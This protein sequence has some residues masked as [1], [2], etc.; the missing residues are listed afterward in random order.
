MKTLNFLIA[1]LIC[2]MN[3][4]ASIIKINRDDTYI[5][6]D[7][8]DVS[9]MLP[10]VDFRLV[11]SDHLTPDHSPYLEENKSPPIKFYYNIRQAHSIQI[12]HVGFTYYVKA[13]YGPDEFYYIHSCDCEKAA[14]RYVK[15][16]FE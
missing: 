12:V 9:H 4:D 13:I 3:L 14:I 16:L 8:G 15:D 2:V 7:S 6:D 1:T 10:A 11:D 5:V